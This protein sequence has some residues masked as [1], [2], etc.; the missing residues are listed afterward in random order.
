MAGIVPRLTRWEQGLGTAPDPKNG[1]RIRTEP[2]EKVSPAGARIRRLAGRGQQAW[3]PYRQ[4]VP[5]PQGRRLNHPRPKTRTRKTVAIAKRVQRPKFREANL[6]LDGQRPVRPPS[7]VFASAAELSLFFARRR[8]S[9]RATAPRVVPLQVVA[10]RKAKVQHPEV[11]RSWPASISRKITLRNQTKRTAGI[12][13]AVTKSL[14]VFATSR[15]TPRIRMN[16]S[17]CPIAH[18]SRQ[19]TPLASW[20]SDTLTA[21]S[22][23]TAPFPDNEQ[24][25]PSSCSR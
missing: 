23:P 11:I 19:P 9:R 21:S 18:D 6:S 17:N 12:S 5:I 25:I 4:A 7:F 13:V 24:A 16:R 8:R 3:R 1:L 15:W 10:D 22:H 20:A 14:E 2:I